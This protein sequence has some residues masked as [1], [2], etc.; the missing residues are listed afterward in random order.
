MNSGKGKVIN[1]GIYAHKLKDNEAFLK[2]YEEEI[3]SR[4]I[5]L[6]SAARTIRT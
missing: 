4:A 6:N 2:F 5:D 3:I 1:I